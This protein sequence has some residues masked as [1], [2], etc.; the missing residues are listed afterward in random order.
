MADEAVTRPNP[1][2]GAVIVED[3]EVV[4]RGHFQQDGEPHAERWALR[5]LG[6]RPKEGA[7]MYVTLEPCS[8]KGRTGACTEALIEA[9]VSRV[10]VGAMDPTEAHRGNGELNDFDFF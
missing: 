10:V 5:T 1:R 4:S 9:G 8:T 6:R 3:G 7:A 2:V